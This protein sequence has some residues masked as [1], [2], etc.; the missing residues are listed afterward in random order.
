MNMEVPPAAR[1][2]AP[3]PDD[4]PTIERL[5]RSFAQET[6]RAKVNLERSGIPLRSPARAARRS[7][8]AL[9]LGI[10]ALAVILVAAA[11]VLRVGNQLDNGEISPLDSG[12]GTLSTRPP[13]TLPVS[14]SVTAASAQPS[15]SD[16]YPPLLPAPWNA[17][18]WSPTAPDPW[19]GPGN[20]FVQ[21]V[22]ADG[23]G[24]VAV[25]YETGTKPHGVVWFSADGRTWQRVPDPTGTFEGAR[26]SWVVE[27]GG[28]LVALGDTGSDP[29]AGPSAVWTSSDGAMT[30]TPVP[31]A[32]QT[33]AGLV[34]QGVTRGPSGFIAY[35][36]D[37]QR[38]VFQTW[39]SADG[40]VWE[41]DQTFPSTRSGSVVGTARG[42]FAAVDGVEWLSADGRSWTRAN[43]TNSDRLGGFIP[44]ADGLVASV[45]PESTCLAC[46]GPIM[47]A[48][49]RQ[50]SDGINWVDLAG[51]GP[52]DGK[53]GSGL[54]G[55]MTS[56]GSRIVY[57]A[58][59]GRIWVS[60]DG[61]A[62]HAPSAFLADP[63]SVG[64]VDPNAGMI[65]VGDR[66]LVSID[67]DS[68][69][70]TV[71]FG[72]ASADAPAG[73]LP[74]FPLQYNDG[75]TDRQCIGG[76]GG[77]PGV[78]CIQIGYYL[79]NDSGA[80]QLIRMQ[81]A[82]NSVVRVAAD[83]TGYLTGIGPIWDSGLPLRV[84]LLSEQCDVIDAITANGNLELFTIHTGVSNPLTGSINLPAEALPETPFPT[85]AAC[86]G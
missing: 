63:S 80:D 72:A 86:G 44:G 38:T 7:V 18:T 5:E 64:A 76:E 21:H 4:R 22:V 60:Q 71:W 69:D 43:G 34:V 35:A 39:I 84:Q 2:G 52:F 16:V 1:D 78:V 82:V 9:P 74:T 57:V 68:G 62:W 37:W 12:S 6:A 45:E 59:S 31:G 36:A 3:A 51:I 48:T 17:I 85:V 27:F 20:R 13:A 46:F 65:A 53:V 66:G 50:S 67:Q 54:G 23:D 61:L 11:V 24:F 47:F 10:G 55:Q 33:F 79:R 75:R 40:R 70:P 83:Q 49:Y 8:S 77:D 15:S 19:H 41:P 73:P 56:D 30:W 14:S 42:Y 58:P 28:V 32:T 26:L 25:G 81:G 29:G